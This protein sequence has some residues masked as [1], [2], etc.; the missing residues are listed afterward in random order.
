M[1][2]NSF[3]ASSAIT[4]AAYKTISI[5]LLIRQ[6]Q[7]QFHLN[8]RHGTPRARLW[9]WLGFAAWAIEWLWLAA[10][11]KAQS[12]PAPRL[13]IQMAG[14]QLNLVLSGLPGH[15]YEFE[16]SSNLLDWAVLLM[17]NSVT[18]N[19]EVAASASAGTGTGFYRA[20]DLG[21][22][23]G[24]PSAVFALLWSGSS[25]STNPT[26]LDLTIAGSVV[27]TVEDA[28]GKALTN[29]VVNLSPNIDQATVSFILANGSY[30]VVADAYPQPNGAGVPFEEARFF[31][32]VTGGAPVTQ[33]FTLADNAITNLI[34]T[35]TNA[36]MAVG[37]SLQ[38]SATAFDASNDVVFVTAQS[39][40]LTWTSLT[41]P[42]ATVDYTGKLTGVAPGVAT[43]QVALTTNLALTAFATVTDAFQIIG[44]MITNV[45][46][47]AQSLTI[48][49]S[50]E[51]N[52]TVIAT[53]ANGEH[54]PLAASA[55]VW[56]S[57]SVSKAVVDG[58]GASGLLI[59]VAPGLA[60]ITV[61]NKYALAAPVTISV[62][63]TLTG[64]SLGDGLPPPTHGYII[65]D[66]GALP[67]E[68]S[69]LPAALNRAG[70][71]AGLSWLSLSPTNDT[72]NS[73]TANNPT[74]QA[75]IWKTS[76]NSVMTALQDLGGGQAVAESI[77]GNDEVVGW[78]IK[79]NTISS[80]KQYRHAVLWQGS[81]P[82]DLNSTLSTYGSLGSPNFS[83]AFRINDQGQVI[84][85]ASLISTNVPGW[86]SAF[87]LD[88][89][90]L[91]IR[92]AYLWE[93]LD[94]RTQPL[95]TPEAINNCGF[96]AG[97]QFI[98]NGISA[99]YAYAFVGNVYQVTNAQA[100][101]LE[102][103]PGCQSGLAYSVNDLEQAAGVCS[104]AS[105]TEP[106]YTQPRAVA[107]RGNNGA[108]SGNLAT[109]LGTNGYFSRAWCIN[110]FG[111]VVGDSWP[112]VGGEYTDSHA[113]LW[114]TNM[115][116]LN[117]YIP[118]NS[119]W[120]L[121]VATG[122]NDKGQIIGQGTR[123]N[124]LGYRSFLLTPNK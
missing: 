104:P 103:L 117:A 93:G 94:P 118:T 11:A 35:P 83:D 65:T 122:I 15:T 82:K 40:A 8:N 73:G 71:G 17:T 25:P 114:V 36:T 88:L 33:T 13:G 77:N 87:L 38:L 60:N 63:V 48:G 45:P 28:K 37:G 90:A 46:P 70:H 121:D 67:A 57:S 61:N 62:E 59:G 12:P 52:L 113:V 3:R 26:P 74:P 42:I 6:N 99:S 76:Q 4:R 64:S 105:T 112:S 10:P 9:M 72:P 22:V 110:N 81:S 1:K 24:S 21:P 16:T 102:N 80:T 5:I 115:Y 79:P 31:F 30:T 2:S 43:I 89:S 92:V 54:V 44:M 124:E 7:K 19:A 58:S 106:E 98:F 68:I 85:Q 51:T 47:P 14:P 123:T 20:V 96:M 53:N 56:S 32:T 49:V 86:S 120:V 91:P 66:L 116:D 111:T 107:W 50:Q 27:F 109:D 108:P 69:S 18:S 100:A 34:I 95:P 101:P 55:M 78:S 97:G 23:A 41:L 29:Q 75:Y 39:G 119:G 84:G